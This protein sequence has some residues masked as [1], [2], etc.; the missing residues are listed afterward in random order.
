MRYFAE[1]SYNG[2]NYVGWQNQPNGVAVQAKIE[3]ALSTILREDIAIVGCGRTD[4]R[5]HAKQYFIH[6]DV[7]QPIIDNLT[8]RINKFLPKDIAFKRF[9]PVA[10]KAHARFDA[11]N[12]SYEYYIEY[13]KNP[14]T[15]NTAYFFP[16]AHQLDMKLLQAAAKLLLDY[17]EFFPFCKANSDAKTMCCEIR[18]SY[19]SLDEEKDQLVFRISADRFLRG[20]VRLIVGMC[21]NVALHKLPLES[22]QQALDQQVRLEKD[23]SV[24]AHGLYLSEVAYDFPLT[25][26]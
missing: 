16:F 5:V 21:L 9:I 10:D 4:A 14:L 2:T 18:T 6:F 25:T 8:N 26:K 19:W 13:Y 22:V 24:P 20:M 11:T 12:R 15:T 23:L 17:D 7:S 1:L 3:S